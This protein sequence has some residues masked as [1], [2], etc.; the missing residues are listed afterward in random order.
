MNLP[1]L[2]DSVKSIALKS[3]A[4]RV[5]V[6]SQDRLIDAPPSADMS[7]SLPGAQNCIIWAY[8]IPPGT[9]E[10]YLSKKERMSYKKNLYFAY[11]TA[12]KSAV[13]VAQSI[14]TNSHYKAVP[15]IPNVGYRGTGRR[16]KVRLRMGRTLLR[17]GLAKRLII[18]II[19]RTFGAKAIP[20]FSLRYGAVAAGLG[21]LG[22]SGNLFI[23]D[24][25]SAVYLA[26]VLTTAPIEPDPLVEDPLC[27][28]CKT[29]VQACPTGLF[30]LDEAEPP[31]I[32][33][34]RQEIYAKRNAYAR[35]YFGCGG[36]AGLGPGGKWSTWTPDHEFLKE[37]SEEQMTQPQYRERLLGKLFFAKDTPKAQR[38]FNKKIIIE[39]MNGGI[40]GNIGLRSLEDTHPT[41]GAC[42]AVCVADPKQRKRLLSF[43][44]TSGKLFV[45]DEGQEI[46]RKESEDGRPIDFIPPT[47]VKE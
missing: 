26:G 38:E 30:S 41:C 35:C 32:I 28:K 33:A 31:V 3:G 2:K 1:E 22:W 8:P 16:F 46:V 5:G 40:L 6:G 18:K 42:Q 7:Y 27:N 19:A 45:N 43:L 13:D 15:V 23:K 47:E 39:F 36:L 9:L 34:G 25:G 24:Y 37:V 4:I 11:S 10:N 20:M 29:C 21:R 12:W 44:Q 14:E 17:L